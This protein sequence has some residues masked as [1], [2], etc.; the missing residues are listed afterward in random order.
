MEILFC[1]G[2]ISSILVLSHK[3]PLYWWYIW[4]IWP[5]TIIIVASWKKSIPEIT[6]GNG[7]LV[8]KVCNMVV[9]RMLILKASSSHWNA[10]PHCRLGKIYIYSVECLWSVHDQGYIFELCF[11]VC[12]FFIFSPD[13]RYNTVASDQIASTSQAQQVNGFVPGWMLWAKLSI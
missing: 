3:G 4:V 6:I 5:M 10:I 7:R 9:H 1:I 13:Y 11:E 2:Q 12:P 8:I